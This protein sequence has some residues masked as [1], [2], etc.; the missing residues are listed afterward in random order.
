MLALYANAGIYLHKILYIL[1]GLWVKNM[2][3]PFP[4]SAEYKEGGYTL[5]KALNTACIMCFYKDALSCD[6]I[7]FVQDDGLEKEE[8]TLCVCDKG[9]EIKYSTE[10]GRF[11]AITTLYQMVKEGAELKFVCI[12]DKPDFE[13]R[14][15]MLDISRG[16]IAKVETIKKLIDFL[17]FLKYN[18]LQLYMEDFCF[19]YAA[20]PQVNA[21]FD[22]LT[23][24]DIEELDAYCAERFIDL[25]P[26]QNCFGHMQEWLA[27]PDFK[28]LA[29]GDGEKPNSGT[30]N[31]IH[32]E[33]FD[34]VDGLFDSLLPYF[35]SKYVN[36]GMDEAFG[37]GRFQIEEY[38]K[39]KGKDN[40]FMDYLNRMSKSIG[41]K[42]GK[43]VMF[44]ADMI[45]SY[46]DSHTRIPKDAI[47]LEWGYDLIQSQVM[48]DHCAAFKEK[49]VTFYTCPATHNHLSF[50]GR[51]DVATFNIRT[52][53][54]VGLKYGAK[55]L[56]LTDW[57]NSYGNPQ[58]FEWSWF[59]IALSA[60]YGWNVGEEQNGEAFKTHYINSARALVDEMFFGGK[61]VSELL[62]RLSNYYLL[63]PERIHNGTICGHLIGLPLSQSNYYTYFDLKDCGNDFYFNHVLSYV[64]DV[65]AEIEALDIDEIQ[66]REILINAKMVV[67]ATELCK[68]RYGEKTLAPEKKEE[69]C[70]LIDWMAAEYKE[71][72][73][74]DN[75]EKG[76]EIFVNVLK[77][78]REEIAAL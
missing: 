2:L 77:D 17:A 45:T 27:H 4:K 20:Y 12:S 54:E 76:V 28:H 58:F 39:E 21:H 75:Y 65:I 60:Q 34:F 50:T 56:L 26:N 40:V 19:K 48:A 8:Y 53:A 73:M 61:P 33:T 36:I 1:K 5:K 66:K 25:V 43:K 11:R 14:G 57:G 52:A 15:Y 16:K 55:G 59:Y 78:R 32:P 70:A 44:W 22:C 71:L 49:G 47:A 72:W 67:L 63:E 69:L 7:S 18:E 13:R 24:E 42:H 31:P 35:N 41:E 9:I 3:F 37:L 62:Y 38:C 23:P 68:P 29:L 74:R 46:P 10:E 6:E 64:K 30:I 51:G